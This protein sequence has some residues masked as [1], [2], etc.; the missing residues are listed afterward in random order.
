MLKIELAADDRNAITLRVHGRLVGPWVDELQRTCE[1]IIAEARP[2]VLDLAALTFADGR[3]VRLLQTLADRSVR[4]LHCSAFV[5][6]QLRAA[7]R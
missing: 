6:E 5:T 4:L 7:A 1:R 2:P 3:G